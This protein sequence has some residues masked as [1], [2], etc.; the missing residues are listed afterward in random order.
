MATQPGKPSSRARAFYASVLDTL[1]KS[2]IPFMIGGAYALAP[3][4]GIVRHT[5]DLDIFLKPDD[6]D[7]TLLALEAAG[8]R[9][10]RTFPHW[11]AKAFD[12]DDEHTLFVDLIYRSGNAVAEVDD[13]WFEH[14][15]DSEV[16]GIPVKLIPAE[17]SLW[18]K[19]FVMERERF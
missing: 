7:Q 12:T 4:T 2:E 13:G 19:A 18:S 17:E 1:I 3:L 9:T 6:L 11:L 15:L 5:K 10:E 16:L 14:A 8:Y